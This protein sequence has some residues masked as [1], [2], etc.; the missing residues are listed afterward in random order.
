MAAESIN[1]ISAVAELARQ[2]RRKTLQLMEVSDCG[3]LTWA[4]PGTSNHLLWHA[5][6]AVWAQDVLTIEPLAGRGELPTG[7]AEKFGM[8]SRPATVDSWPDVAEVRSRLA[9]Q[10]R[11]DP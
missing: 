5:G 1:A 10:L 7:W 2:V 4:P 11:A 8:N 9:M 3:W 6:H